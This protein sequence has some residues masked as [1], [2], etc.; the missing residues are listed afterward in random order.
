MFHSL[1]LATLQ[2]AYI[3]KK[4]FVNEM[5]YFDEESL[6]SVLCDDVLLEV[7]SFLDSGSLK[8]ALLVCKK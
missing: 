2:F 6:I 3:L 4:L 1:F 8:N 5:N 7:F